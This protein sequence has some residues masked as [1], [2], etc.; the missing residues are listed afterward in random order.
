MFVFLDIGFTLMGGPS[1]GPGRRLLRH[2]GL[3]DSA[4]T[5]LNRLL[6]ESFFAD[7]AELAQG[8]SRRFDVHG[9]DPF[10]IVADL[11]RRQVD[12]ADP[13]PGSREGL[14]RLRDAGIPFGF[15][16]NIWEPFLAGFARLFPEEY[17]DCPLFASCRLGCSKPDL[18]LYRKALSHTGIDPRDAVMIGDTYENDIAPARKLGMKTIWVLSRPEKERSDLIAVLNKTMPPPDRTVAGID[19]L[20]TEM[21]EALWSIHR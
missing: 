18:Q 12:E 4:K 3:P 8:L 17:Q 5:E 21:I 9:I 19:Q 1:E 10:P 7:P 20:R 11:W 15:V 13:L 16:T 14:R 6:F 2:L